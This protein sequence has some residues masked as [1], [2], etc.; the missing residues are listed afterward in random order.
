MADQNGISPFTVS[1]LTDGTYYF[2]VV[3]HNEYGD[4]L[5]NCIIVTVSI[6]EDVTDIPGYHLLYLGITIFLISIVLIQFIKNRIK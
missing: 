5:S 4:T 6:A 1:G 2:I 3:A